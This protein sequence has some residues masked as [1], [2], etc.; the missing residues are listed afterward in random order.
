[1]GK[2]FHDV[3]LQGLNAVTGFLNTQ[4]DALNLKS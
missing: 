2:S 1:M 3:V 4:N